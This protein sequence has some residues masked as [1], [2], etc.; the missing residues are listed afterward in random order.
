MI[1]K[2]IKKASLVYLEK[3]EL[4]G[5]DIKNNNLKYAKHV[6]EKCIEDIMKG[7]YT[8]TRRRLL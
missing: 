8:H 4:K 1:G 2:P 5:V 3:S 6:A 7:I